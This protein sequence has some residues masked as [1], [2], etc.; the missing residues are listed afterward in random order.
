MTY[1]QES[2]DRQNVPVEAD[3]RE[4]DAL[5]ALL[6]RKRG[7][8]FSGYKRA[9][10]TRRVLRRVSSVGAD[11][12]A[13]YVE[14][15]ERSPDELSDLLTVLLINVTAFFRDRPA[16]DALAARLPTLIDPHARTPIRVWSAG[17]SSGEEPYSLAMLLR[18]TLGEDAFA[19]RV[20]I[21][22]TDIDDDALSIAR[23]AIYSSHSLE[24]VPPH[25]VDKYFAPA[26]GRFTLSGELRRDVIFGRHDLLR[27]APIPQVDLLVCRNALMYFNPATQERV[28]ENLRFAMKPDGVLFLGKAEMLLTHS[29]LFAPLDLKWRLF[30]PTSRPS[31][32]QLRA[33]EAESDMNEAVQSR[34]RRLVLDVGPLAQ[35]IL[36]PTGRLVVAN[37]RA[38]QLL[39]VSTREIGL[40]M[41][42]V[43]AIGRS[44]ELRACIERARTE[45]RVACLNELELPRNDGDAVFV[46]VEATP[47]LSETGMLIGVQVT[48]GDATRTHRLRTDL[49]RS[50]SDLETAKEE[51]RA[52]R[53]ELETTNDVLQSTNQELETT[54]EELRST[55]EELEAMNE[56]LQSTN[57]ELQTINEELRQRDTEL[58]TNTALFSAVLASL[59][60]G[61]AVLDRALHVQ[62]WNAKMVAYSGVR[63]HEA[64]GKFFPT[65]ALGFESR[66]PLGDVATMLRFAVDARDEKSCTVEAGPGQQGIFELRVAPLLG[67]F[68]GGVIV[69]VTGEVG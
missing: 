22:A 12:I 20:K 11:S 23:E 33:A 32:H 44:P 61:V 40:G 57:E 31:A 27:D 53:Q 55:N 39:S 67:G 4:L 9:S 3:A 59:R 5:L 48:F 64:M 51:L 19:R 60:T 52:A 18:E 43:A 65:L 47:V 16:W 10:L 63:A 13:E 17:C 68:S 69:L 1:G 42:E 28:L 41:G 66:L 6:R 7:F 46:D 26:S 37:R 50:S 58:N 24:D 30:T 29:H 34:L 2:L 36:D 25:L 54:N 49:R 35:I 15:L 62:M 21:Y 45:R 38:T 56:E 14:Y 8:D